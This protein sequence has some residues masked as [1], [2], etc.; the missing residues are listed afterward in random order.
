MHKTLKMI[1]KYPNIAEY[2]LSVYN[3]FLM[4]EFPAKVGWASLAK[5]VIND[6]LKPPPPQ[7]PIR[8]YKTLKTRV[9]KHTDHQKEVPDAM[10]ERERRKSCCCADCGR[11]SNFEKQHQT[12]IEISQHRNVRLKSLIINNLKSGD[13]SPKKH[14]ILDEVK[15]KLTKSVQMQQLVA[16]TR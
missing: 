5:E 9:R 11:M 15:N 16:S 10:D 1:T 2:N 8:I 12:N 13:N 6:G 14:N 7:T 3:N 4:N